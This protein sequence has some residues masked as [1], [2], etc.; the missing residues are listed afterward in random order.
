MSATRLEQLT[1][2]MKNN[3]QSKARDAESL[4]N[5]GRIQEIEAAKAQLERK[6][7]QEQE[8]NRALRFKSGQVF[9]ASLEKGAPVKLGVKR[10]DG[11]YYLA[12]D[13]A[14]MRLMLKIEQLGSPGLLQRLK[15]AGDAVSDTI[16]KSQF[17][18]FLQKLGMLP[19]DILAL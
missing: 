13:D 5:L 17:V 6:L 12:D 3:E 8:R 10:T 9:L 11:D 2:V 1:V 14:L 19:T 18:S 15:D 7:A 16:T 4:R